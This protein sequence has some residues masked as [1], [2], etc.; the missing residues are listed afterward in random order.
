LEIN[1][2]AMHIKNQ[3]PNFFTLLNLLS[4]VFS[5]YLGMTGELQLSAA[6]IFLAAILD[7]FDGLLARVLNA[8]TE[9]GGQ[10]DSLADIVSFGV[11]PAF[12]LF[13]TFRMEEVGIPETS[14]LPFIS[15]VIPLFSAWR[16][17]KFN[18]DSEQAAIFKGL[19]T[20]ASGILL[21]SFPIIILVCLAENKGFY[22]DL[23]TNP[24]FLA[25]TAV[26]VSVL[27]VSNLPMFALKF[28]TASWAEN[29]TRYIF[30]ILSVFLLILLKLAAVPLIVLLYLLLSV[31]YHFFGK[32]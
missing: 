13:H 17:A 32:S 2:L 24:Y 7:F 20:P 22:Y 30:L 28:S 15:F 12:V 26:V 5:I 25:A 23:V 9:I 3:I 18:T 8:K 6:L 10:L 21:A 29:Q 16:L 27:M 1:T 4:G 19:P 31:T 14:Y 11:A